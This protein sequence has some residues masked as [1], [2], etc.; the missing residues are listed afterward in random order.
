MIEDY[1]HVGGVKRQARKT[2]KSLV[3][4]D[5]RIG[6]IGCDERQKNRGCDPRIHT[7]TVCSY[8]VGPLAENNQSPQDNAKGQR[9]RV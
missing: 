6:L 9:G 1:R 4:R 3:V 5:D 7:F 8:E 2:A